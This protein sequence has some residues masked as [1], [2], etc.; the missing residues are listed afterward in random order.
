MNRIESRLRFRSA[1]LLGVRTLLLTV[2]GAAAA[3]AA[4][5]G[6]NQSTQ[7]TGP[8]VSVPFVSFGNVRSFDARNDTG[9]YLES[10]S[11]KWYY[12]KF[13]SPC[14][15]IQ[16]ALAIQVLPSGTDT[17]DR[18]SKIRSRESGTCMLTSL[19]AAPTPPD[20]ARK[21]A[22]AKDDTASD[23]SPARSDDTAGK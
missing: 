8:E 17:L 11:G 13:F 16:Y 2:I 9:I 12:G 20:R 23:S 18:W 22:A 21:H 3:V 10:T 6:T 14:I 5:S 1:A 15:G 4:E 19:V 7:P